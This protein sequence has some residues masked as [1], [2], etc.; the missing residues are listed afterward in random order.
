MQSRRAKANQADQHGQVRS[1]AGRACS[2]KRLGVVWSELGARASGAFL[3]KA[4]AVSSLS[5]F[6]FLLPF[7]PS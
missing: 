7:L 6:D 1:R 3:D 2:W 5:M 4:P